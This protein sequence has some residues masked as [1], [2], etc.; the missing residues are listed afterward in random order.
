MFLKKSYLGTEIR[1]YT[2]HYLVHDRKKEVS[3]HKFLDYIGLEIAMS[4]VQFNDIDEY[5]KR[6]IFLGHVDFQRVMSRDEF[7]VIRSHMKCIPP[8]MTNDSQHSLLDP[9]WHSSMLLE[10]FQTNCFLVSVNT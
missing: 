2:H 5:W 8:Y 7:Q 9:L 4:I 10:H 3:Q 6:D 1:G